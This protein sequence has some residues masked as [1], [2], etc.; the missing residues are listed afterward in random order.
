MPT[1]PS[2][3]GV[4]VRS[5]DEV[6]GDRPPETPAHPYL[7]ARHLRIDRDRAQALMIRW[8]GIAL[9]LSLALVVALVVVLLW[10]SRSSRLIP[11]V[12]QV[13]DG[14]TILD[15][16]LL[17]D[18][19][20]PPDRAILMREL[21]SFI[22]NARTITSDRAAQRELILETYA[23]AAGRAVGILNDSYRQNP[24]FATA[25]RSTVTPRIT[26]VLEVSDDVWQIDWT[27]TERNLQGAVTER[28][29]WRALLTV[30]TRPPDDVEEAL[31]NP[32]GIRVVDLD[33]TP[34]ATDSDG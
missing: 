34:V 2:A 21:R 30:A 18:Q 13:D 12:V 9:V 4:P 5:S 33:W 20:G 23:Y 7:Q 14:G 28:T 29:D 19:Q 25:T 6:L 27:E 16:E 15:T 31:A 32:L 8:G 11:Y 22:L 10:Q 24:P 26:S 3:F 1:D 17:E